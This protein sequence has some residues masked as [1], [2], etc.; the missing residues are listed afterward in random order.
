MQGLGTDWTGRPS[1][2]KANESK[3][4]L[5]TDADRADGG[6]EKSRPDFRVRKQDCN[7]R[8]SVFLCSALT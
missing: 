7:P 6:R 4:D 5:D 2:S 8:L 1:S 3:V